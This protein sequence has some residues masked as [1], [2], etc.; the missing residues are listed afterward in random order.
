MLASVKK[1]YA[2]VVMAILGFVLVVVIVSVGKHINET[3][4]GGRSLNTWATKLSATD[5]NIS[6]G[7]INEIRKMGTNGIPLVIHLDDYLSSSRFWIYKRRFDSWLNNRFRLVSSKERFQGN[8][9]RLLSEFN[10]WDIP[11]LVDFLVKGEHC[12]AMEALGMMGEAPVPA[13][14]QLLHYTNAPSVRLI[15]TEIL[16]NIAS[17]SVHDDWSAV[18]Q[19]LIQCLKD[20]DPSVRVA[21]AMVLAGRQSTCE[22]TIPVLLN[23]ITNDNIQIR[24]TADIALTNTIPRIRAGGGSGVLFSSRHTKN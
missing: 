13:L 1:Q 11:I 22:L 18:I 24:A 5:T 12:S 20:H 7:A 9:S 15:A 10:S 16:G 14:N 17:H 6:A 2:V 21:S 8:Y 19:A 23:L 3:L 4:Y